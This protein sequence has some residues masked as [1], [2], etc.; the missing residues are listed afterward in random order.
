M[1]GEL[2]SIIVLLTHYIKD[3]YAILRNQHTNGFGYLNLMP[4]LTGVLADQ[5]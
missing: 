5:A 2:V 3:Y 4:D 1:R